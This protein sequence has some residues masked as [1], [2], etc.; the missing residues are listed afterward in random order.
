MT[1]ELWRRLAAEAIGTALL[2]IFGAG[3]FV[4]A[5]VMG[6]G[7]LGYA[8]MGIIGFSFAFVIAATAYEGGRP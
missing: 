7:Q 6:R 4:A 3:S 8:A 2:V 1:A 5:L